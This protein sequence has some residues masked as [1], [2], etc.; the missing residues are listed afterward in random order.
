V[1]EAIGEIVVDGNGQMAHE[2]PPGYREDNSCIAT[3]SP[4]R[5]I[6]GRW[7]ASTGIYCRPIWVREVSF[8]PLL[9]EG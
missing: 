4:A 8:G 9:S 3:I 7:P 6:V 1:I 2:L 5:A